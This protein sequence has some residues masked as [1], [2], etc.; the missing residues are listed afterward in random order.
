MISFTPGR[1]WK[2]PFG[3]T[4]SAL[5]LA[6]TETGDLMK[7]LLAGAS[8]LLLTLLTV[9][10]PAAGAATTGTGADQLRESS[11]QP[12]Y[13]LRGM[14]RFRTVGQDQCTLPQEERTGNW[15]CL[16]SSAAPSAREMVIQGGFCN[17]RGCWFPIDNFHANNSVNGTMGYGDEELGHVTL[18]SYNRL[19]G[20]QMITKTGLTIGTGTRNLDAWGDLLRGDSDTKGQ[21]VDGQSEHRDRDGLSDGNEWKPWGTDGY[22]SYDNNYGH[23]ANAIEYGWGKGGYSGRWWVY[24]KSLIAKD[25]DVEDSV[26]TYKFSDNP[27]FRFASSAD[28]GWDPL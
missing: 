11:A 14:Q 1:L 27:D 4:L 5:G 12:H 28:A 19:N 10:G 13:A 3:S 23:H 25:Q 6:E 9:P 24:Q 15:M 2:A 7:G 16:S 21:V 26:V 18:A 8:A 17:G 22:K 20:G